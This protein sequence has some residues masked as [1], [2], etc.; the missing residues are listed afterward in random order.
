M[1][2]FR[3]AAQGRHAWHTTEHIPSDPFSSHGN[4]RIFQESIITEEQ[5]EKI[6]KN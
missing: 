2:L 4:V 6:I 5:R 1:V 3:K